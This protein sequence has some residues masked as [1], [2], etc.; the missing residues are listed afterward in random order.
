MTRSTVLNTSTVSLE[1]L[2]VRPY[3]LY[4]LLDIFSFTFYPFPFVLS[5]LFYFPFT[6]ITLDSS[7]PYWLKAICDR[8]KQLS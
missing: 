1:S 2:C 7:P 8:A 6:R 5:K 4:L 3:D